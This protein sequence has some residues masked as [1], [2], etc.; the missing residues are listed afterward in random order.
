[1]WVLLGI[2]R[3]RQGGP[4]SPWTAQGIPVALPGHWH[5]DSATTVDCHCRAHFLVNSHI[6]LLEGSW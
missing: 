2:Q 3:L 4:H 6:R 5:K 1:M